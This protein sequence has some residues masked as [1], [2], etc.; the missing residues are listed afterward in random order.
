MAKKHRSAPTPKLP[1]KVEYYYRSCDE[2]TKD[3]LESILAESRKTAKRAYNKHHLGSLDLWE[4][5]YGKRRR[6]A[7]RRTFPSIINHHGLTGKTKGFVTA[8]EV[9]SNLNLYTHHTLETLDEDDALLLAAALWFMDHAD[10]RY[11]LSEFLSGVDWREDWDLPYFYDL[12]FSE[13]MIFAAVF[14]LQNRTASDR[15]ILDVNPKRGE[16]ADAFDELLA[17]IP[18]DDLRRA[19]AHT[20]A[21]FWSHV[22]QF[23]DIESALAEPYMKAV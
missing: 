17:L 12:R 15:Y 6:D 22:D 14:I 2:S 23:Y 4:S 7:V 3:G 1:D 10:D 13:D 21:L 11:Q 8:A 9:W 5:E 16:T 19:I 18:P 20:R